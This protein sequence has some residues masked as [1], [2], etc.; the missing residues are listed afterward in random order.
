MGFS[1]RKVDST[2][3]HLIVS[4]LNDYF[5]QAPLCLSHQAITVMIHLQYVSSASILCKR[6]CCIEQACHDA[7]ELCSETH[8]HPLDLAND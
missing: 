6:S 5:L 4:V 3:Q 1:S 7:Q 8:E 2:T